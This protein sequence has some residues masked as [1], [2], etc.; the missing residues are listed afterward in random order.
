MTEA[1][2]RWFHFS[3]VFLKLNT[4]SQSVLSYELEKILLI[5]DAGL[6]R[7]TKIT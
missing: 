3:E 7:A 6:K 4:D 5:Y 1:L 2:R